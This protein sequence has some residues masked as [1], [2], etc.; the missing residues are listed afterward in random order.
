MT[1]IATMDRR[2]AHSLW[3][4][5][6]FCLLVSLSLLMRHVA[7]V[8]NNSE[9][10]L[11]PDYMPYLYSTLHEKMAEAMSINNCTIVGLNWYIGEHDRI[12]QPDLRAKVVPPKD[13]TRARWGEVKF[14]KQVLEN[15]KVFN[16]ANDALCQ[17][18][19]FW[20]YRKGHFR[21]SKGC[22]DMYVR[23][24]GKKVKKVKRYAAT[25]HPSHMRCDIEAAKDACQSREKKSSGPF[26]VGE[27]YRRYGNFPF[28]VTTQDT[29]VSRSGMPAFTCGPFGLFSSCEAAKE[30]IRVAAGVVENVTSCQAAYRDMLA[31]PLSAQSVGNIMAMP[32]HVAARSHPLCPF[33][34]YNKIFVATQY[35]DTQI[36][37]FILEAMPKIVFH[38]DYLLDNP[39]VA[40]HYGFTKKPTVPNFVLPHNYFKWFGLL[41]RLVN[42]TVYANQITI[43]REGGCQ[44]NTYN[45]W[46]TLQQRDTLLR[47]ALIKEPTALSSMHHNFAAQQSTEFSAREVAEMK[48]GRYANILNTF[49]YSKME[50]VTGKR[51]IVII[52]RN[53]GSSYIQNF[54]DLRYRIWK[55]N[56][57]VIMKEEFARLYPEYEVR[58]FSD[59]DKEL[60]ACPPCTIRLF[61]RAEIVVSIHGAGMTNTM[62]M[63]PGSM[64]VE[65]LPY[66]DS[67]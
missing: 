21:D 63:K 52:E 55:N 2:A 56:S 24:R 42:G 8:R 58:S 20:G 30:G 62:Y 15:S 26:T 12:H 25:L 49:N 54:K 38:L 27:K 5:S 13:D 47:L 31:N 17:A 35:D 41:D 16:L 43:P 48:S 65:V 66:F 40:I 14:E 32:S 39:D 33:H 67:R 1:V 11:V 4:R 19:S 29:L 45:A 59:L 3:R 23:V 51:F 46:E 44:D 61:H 10:P 64:V 22:G 6:L 34:M 57:A 60:M 18:K 37:Q 28:V 9:Y 53:R 50:S 36:G 7:P